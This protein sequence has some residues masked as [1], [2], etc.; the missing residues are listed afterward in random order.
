MKMRNTF[1]F[2]WSSGHFKFFARK[3]RKMRKEDQAFLLLREKRLRKMK[4]R[5][6]PI[7]RTA[8][9][10]LFSLVFFIPSLVEYRLA[11]ICFAQW[12]T[13]FG[14]KNRSNSPTVFTPSFLLC[15]RIFN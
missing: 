3:G 7:S 10:A 11:H 9:I 6:E 1:V 12:V 8:K 4:G 14:P 2:I 5:G 13:V 15:C